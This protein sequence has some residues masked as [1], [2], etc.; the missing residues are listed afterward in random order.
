MHLILSPGETQESDVSSYPF[1][2]T[3]GPV[4]LH[5]SYKPSL[6]IKKLQIRSPE[7]SLPAKQ[8]QLSFAEVLHFFLF[9]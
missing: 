5:L 1:S 2:F 8:L 9:L 4:F 7:P 3:T 6:Y